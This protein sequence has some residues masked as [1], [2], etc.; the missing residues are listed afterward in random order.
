LPE[1]FVPI[2]VSSG[3]EVLNMVKDTKRQTLRT[4]AHTATSPG[5]PKL[6]QLIRGQCLLSLIAAT[7]MLRVNSGRSPDD[8]VEEF[9][10]TLAVIAAK[11][12]PR[13]L[14]S[15]GIAHA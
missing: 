13:L 3:K 6:R 8:E 1:R 14:F 10:Q 12:R 4:L 11:I 7:F 15:A 5:Y 2:T 9:A